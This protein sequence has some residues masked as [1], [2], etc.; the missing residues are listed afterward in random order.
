MRT[1]PR[2][3]FRRTP[4]ALVAVLVAAPIPGMAEDPPDAGDSDAV[5]PS[6]RDEPA[7]PLELIFFVGYWARHEV[8]VACSARGIGQEEVEEEECRRCAA[9]P[10]DF[11][12]LDP[13]ALPCDEGMAV[14]A[15]ASA[16]LRADASTFSRDAQNAR[17]P[18]IAQRLLALGVRELPFEAF[19]RCG[20]ETRGREGE[21]PLYWWTLGWDAIVE[22]P[23]PPQP[24]SE[25]PLACIALG[26]GTLALSFSRVINEDPW[27]QA[28]ALVRIALPRKAMSGWLRGAGVGFGSTAFYFADPYV[29]PA[30]FSRKGRFAWIVARPGAGARL[31]ITDL[32]KD[33]VVAQGTWAFRGED[34]LAALEKSVA[35][36]LEKAGIEWPFL[37]EP[38]GFPLYLQADVFRAHLRP[39]P[40]GGCG[41]YLEGERAGSKQIARLSD[42]QAARDPRIYAAFPSPFEPRIALGV[43]LASE[44]GPKEPREIA[45]FGAALGT[46]FKP[47]RPGRAPVVGWDPGSC[48]TT[49]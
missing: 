16:G 48:A 23:S 38:R 44:N 33:R 49:R 21:A 13:G 36:E 34:D 2:P 32:V 19:S 28:A 29:T 45:F 46:G 10:A 5:A 18:T 4:L 9:L 24:A 41:L 47:P 12:R 39:E 6:A 30:G 7:K 31:T 35:P 27:E 15:G 14:F 3:V 40:G 37:R 17:A 11:S 26:D 1:R 42:A 22:M 25:T 20:M 8:Y 43:T